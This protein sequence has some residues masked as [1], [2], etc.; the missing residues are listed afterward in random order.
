MVLPKGGKRDW[1]F[2]RINPPFSARDYNPKR[3]I[4]LIVIHHT[5]ADAPF[6]GVDS[7]YDIHRY[8]RDSRGY[9]G[10]GYHFGIDPEGK[11]Y[12][13]RP[14][15][16]IGA[17]CAGYNSK[18]IGIVLW[19]YKNKT[20]AQYDTLREFLLTLQKRFPLA[21][22][23]EHRDLGRTKCPAIDRSKLKEGIRWLK[24]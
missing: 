18:S 6:R 2:Y 15:S 7:W 4:D 19:G 3:V 22:V 13:L 1:V 17:H 20:Q 12:A 16:L 23:A 8:H 21:K 14:L 9:L 24:P 10:I 11:L 5:G